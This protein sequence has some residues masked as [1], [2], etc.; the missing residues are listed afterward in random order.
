MT[1]KRRKGFRRK[2]STLERLTVLTPWR[3][4]RAIDRAAER[5]S[6]EQGSYLSK[7]KTAVRLLTAGLAAEGLLGAGDAKALA[8]EGSTEP[9]LPPLEERMARLEA[10]VGQLELGRSE[11]AQAA[12]G[13]R[14]TEDADA[15]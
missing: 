9:P 10:R 6:E 14:R 7:S 2:P 12:C 3:L 4:A 5:W 1:Q 13:R 8:F 11:R 15:A